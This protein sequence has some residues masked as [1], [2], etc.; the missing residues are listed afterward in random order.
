MDLAKGGETRFGLIA[1]PGD[2]VI[3]VCAAP[4]RVA[5][6]WTPGMSAD[7]SD[8]GAETALVAFAPSR[9]LDLVRSAAKFPSD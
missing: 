3:A 2:G 7:L 8:P 4:A 5:L 1:M 6:A 9:S